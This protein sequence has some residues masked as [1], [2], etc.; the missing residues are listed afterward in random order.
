MHVGVQRPGNKRKPSV[1]VAIP[2]A[3]GVYLILH[4]E[5]IAIATDASCWFTEG[6]DTPDL[7]DARALLDELNRDD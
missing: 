3:R 6:F 1:L 5:F 2:S 7:K 4:I